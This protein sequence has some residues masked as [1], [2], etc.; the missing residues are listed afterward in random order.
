MGARL[1]SEPWHDIC[2]KSVD[3]GSRLVPPNRQS[4]Y[5]SY[6]F[7]HKKAKQGEHSLHLCRPS[8]M[9][10]IPNSFLENITLVH[11]H[12]ANIDYSPPKER[13]LTTTTSTYIIIPAS[14][15]QSKAPGMTRIVT[16]LLITSE[17]EHERSTCHTERDPNAAP[18]H[19]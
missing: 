6:R 12:S 4:L 16:S 1:P 5:I 8:Y 7:S 13:D 2:T 9:T 18:Q 17:E 19:L 15:V 14:L 10:S 3:D 11:I